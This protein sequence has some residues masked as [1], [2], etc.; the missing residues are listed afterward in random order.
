MMQAIEGGMREKQELENKIKAMESKVLQVG[1]AGSA[2]QAVWAAL[3]ALR[4]SVP[5]PL[6][7]ASICPPISPRFPPTPRAA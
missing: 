4:P 7:A 5:P 6:N 2:C 3:S 1:A